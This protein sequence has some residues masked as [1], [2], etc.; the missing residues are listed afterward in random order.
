M[1]GDQKLVNQSQSIKHR[2]VFFRH[3]SVE[4]RTQ[5]QNTKEQR[6]I[7]YDRRIDTENRVSIKISETCTHIHTQHNM[8]H[9]QVLTYTQRKREDCHFVFHESLLSNGGVYFIYDS[10]PLC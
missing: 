3:N 8:Q 1:A 5:K 7:K 6:H 10:P 4:Q 9:M 2:S